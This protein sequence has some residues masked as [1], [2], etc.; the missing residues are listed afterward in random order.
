MKNC[1]FFV[2]LLI[3]WFKKKKTKNAKINYL[4]GNENSIKEAHSSRFS[5]SKHDNSHRINLIHFFMF[6]KKG[7]SDLFIKFSWNKSSQMLYKKIYTIYTTFKNYKISIKSNL[8]DVNIFNNF[9]GKGRKC[10]KNFQDEV[11][12]WRENI[13]QS[14]KFEL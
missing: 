7:I 3:Y 14:I 2:L 1:Y 10:Q 6:F 11:S 8:W 9:W 4:K 12:R 13:S 5:L